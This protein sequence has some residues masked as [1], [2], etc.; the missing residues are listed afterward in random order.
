MKEGDGGGNFPAVHAQLLRR[1]GIAQRLSK[2]EIG[3]AA[4]EIDCGKVL[5]GAEA[6]KQQSCESENDEF[7]HVLRVLRLG[8]RLSPLRAGFSY[9]KL[10]KGYTGKR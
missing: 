1:R 3:V 2:S 6:W 7:F 10:D 8:W 9:E 4:E 5:S